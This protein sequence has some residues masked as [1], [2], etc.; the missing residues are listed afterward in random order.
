MLCEGSQKCVTV[1]MARHYIARH[2]L[3]GLGRD[4]YSSDRPRC[5]QHLLATFA[6][7]SRFPDLRS[8]AEIDTRKANKLNNA[9]ASGQHSGRSWATSSTYPGY[10][11]EGG[12]D[13]SDTFSC[14]DLG[15]V[16]TTTPFVEAPVEGQ[17]DHDRS[18]GEEQ[19]LARDC[20]M[21]QARMTTDVSMAQATNASDEF[22]SF[23]FA[24]ANGHKDGIFDAGWW[25]NGTAMEGWD[26]PSADMAN[27]N[28][29]L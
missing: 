16:S 25:N 22:A 11:F 24:L 8:S 6:Q 28:T 14:P 2:S 23:D 20:N 1:H 9:V 7:T 17:S 19:S 12:R 21:T 4:E 18:T 15:N 3:H 5:A 10:D 29:M 13:D 27:S 26:Y